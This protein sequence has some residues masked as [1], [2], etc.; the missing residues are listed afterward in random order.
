MAVEKIDYVKCSSCGNCFA[1]CPMDV[2]RKTAGLYYIAYREDCMTCHLC[3]LYCKTN[4][5]TI[6]PERAV[7]IAM[8]Y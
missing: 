4:A 7:S 2:F 6:G 8:P 3:A 5:I 1:I